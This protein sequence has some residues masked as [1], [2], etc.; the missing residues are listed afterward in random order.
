M[1]AFAAV[2]VHNAASA[3]ATRLAAAAPATLLDLNTAAADQLLALPGIGKAYSARIIAGRPYTAKSQLTQ[4]GIIP[5]STYARIKDL[6]I[7][8]QAPKK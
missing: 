6:V 3:Q 5:D 8:K 1:L 7:A 2:P 4:K